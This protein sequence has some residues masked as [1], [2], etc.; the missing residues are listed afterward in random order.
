MERH[1]PTVTYFSLYPRDSH[2]RKLAVDH[3]TSGSL[4]LQSADSQVI[5][6]R[7]EE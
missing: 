7:S 6:L 1:N 4:E 5:N 2:L 3:S